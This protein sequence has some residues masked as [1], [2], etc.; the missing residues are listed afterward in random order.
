MAHENIGS[1]RRQYSVTDLDQVLHSFKSDIEGN[2]MQ[3]LK[4]QHVCNYFITKIDLHLSGN[5]SFVISFYNANKKFAHATFHMD[6]LNDTR[7]GLH[8][9]PYTNHIVFNCNIDE[10]YNITL[11]G[12]EKRFNLRLIDIDGQT[13]VESGDPTHHYLNIEL[14]LADQ[15][16]NILEYNILYCIIDI[17]NVLFKELK[18]HA[19]EQRRSFDKPSSEILSV[20]GMRGDDGSQI[21]YYEKYLKYKKKYMELKNKIN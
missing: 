2:L 9:T 4:S 5:D 18:I 20:G 7:S 17:L 3:Y 1:L 15:T 19:L 10:D 16:I 21:N 12:N 14:S 8:E 6:A 13:H 11:T